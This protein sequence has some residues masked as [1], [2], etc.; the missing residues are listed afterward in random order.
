M[1]RQNLFV[2]ISLIL[3]LVLLVA[4][5]FTGCGGEVTDATENVATEAVTHTFA[6]A[7]VFAD[8]NREEYSITTTEKTVGDALVAEGL[9]EGEEGAYGLYVKKVCGV[10]ADY[11][12]D[13]TY[14]ALYVDGSYGMAGVETIKCSEVTSIE[15]RVEK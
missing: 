9:I 4:A 7:A 10:V 12:T 3:V 14:W 2:R 8:G 5:V 15:F 13:G 1:N 6:F 11:D